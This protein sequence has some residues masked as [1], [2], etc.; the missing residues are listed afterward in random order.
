MLRAESTS[1]YWFNLA[2][3][4]ESEKM[5]LVLANPFQVKPSKELDDN[6]HQQ[7]RSQRA[8]DRLIPSRP[9]TGGNQSR[10]QRHP[11]LLHHQGV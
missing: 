11:P 10:V 1:Y 5:P 4:D 2:D 3:Y 6:H 7:E 9:V 8:E